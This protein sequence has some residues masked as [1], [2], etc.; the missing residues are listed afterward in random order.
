MINE[1]LK[2]RMKGFTKEFIYMGF[3]RNDGARSTRKFWEPV[4]D[5]FIDLLM[6]MRTASR[7]IRNS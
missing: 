4:I 2:E 6:K 7:A 3:Q 5:F 1:F